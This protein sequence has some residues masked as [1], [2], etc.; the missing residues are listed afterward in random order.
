MLPPRMAPVE[1]LGIGD[2]EAAPAVV[3][4]SRM[5]PRSAPAWGPRLVDG[6]ALP[7]DSG[8][9]TS[10]PARRGASRLGCGAGDHPQDQDSSLSVPRRGSPGWR[11]HP[12]A[13][14]ARPPARRL[15]R[16]GMRRDAGWL[17]P[18][19]SSG[20]DVAVPAH[21]WPVDRRRLHARVFLVS[22]LTGRAPGVRAGGC[23]QRGSSRAPRGFA[24]QRTGTLRLRSAL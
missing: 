22:G 9:S 21:R 14:L 3:R 13:R 23:R 18:L 6:R 1:R 12:A 16:D 8:R 7:P 4:A 20:A 24:S 11:G 5:R 2:V 17:G 10:L 15:A 19:R